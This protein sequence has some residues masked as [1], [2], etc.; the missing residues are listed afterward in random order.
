MNGFS[1]KDFQDN[2][3]NLEQLNDSMEKVI[4]ECISQQKRLN[5][6][7]TLFDK[8]QFNS[9]NNICFDKNNLLN[10]IPFVLK[11]NVMTKDILTTGSSNMLKDYVPVY[12][13]TIVNKLKEAGALLVGKASMDEL[14]MGGTNKSAHTGPVCNPFDVT[15][16]SGGSSG[17]SAAL[18]GS[19]VVPFAIGSDTG[20][21]IRKPAAFCGVVGFKP[22]WG[23]ISRYGVIPYAS[24]LDTIGAFART[25]HD[26]ALVTSVMSG[27]DENDMTSSLRPVEEYH[28][29]LTDD[30]KQYKVAI[31]KSVIDEMTNQEFVN[32]FNNVVDKLRETGCVVEEV[33]MDKTLLK[34]MLPT[35]KIIANSEATSNHACLDGIKYGNF[36]EGNTTDETM[37]LSRS[38]GFGSH[39]KRRFILGNVAL[40]SQNQERMFKKAKRVRRLIV[41]AT[42]DIFKEYDLFIAPCSGSI[43]PLINDN[44]KELI[45]DENLIVENH[46]LLG[47]F[48]G[49]PSLT[50]PCGFIN[51]M[52]VGINITGNV[53]EE[54]KVLNLGYA[55]EE[56]LGY[57]NQYKGGE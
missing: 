5:A 53:F 1:I 16:I 55:L 30:V 14:A 49:M 8:E 38:S 51:D 23:R 25:V 19:G 56:K 40:A 31:L 33:V 17:G 3:N 27:R 37:I 50:I 13:A 39:I 46:L 20:D 28:T 9:Y 6:F 15:R 34:A 35:Y 43:A 26:V 48:G 11:D 21:S 32:N 29:L 44:S 41:D 7:V 42:V 22:T 2:I 54:Q 18:V 47:N 57:K 36:V 52:P 45:S 24:S 10:S 12:D 4:N